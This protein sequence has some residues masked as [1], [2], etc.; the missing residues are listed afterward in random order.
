MTTELYQE[1]M[2]KYDEKQSKADRLADLRRNEIYEKL[3]EIQDI[4][5]KLLSFNLSLV[6][7]MADTDK[8]RKKTRTEDLKTEMS[9]LIERKAALLTSNGYPA[10][11]MENVYE[12]PLC[13]DTG[14]IENEQCSCFKQAVREGLFADSS[15]KSE[16]DGETFQDFSLDYYSDTFDPRLRTSIRLYMKGV[17]DICKRFSEKP[18]GN[19][20][21]TGHTGLG[22]SYLCHAI[23][24]GLLDKNTDVICDSSFMI[25]DKLLDIRFGRDKDSDYADSI[26]GC[27]VLIID[28]L[29]SE[30]INSAVNTELFNLLNYRLI[31][32]LPTVISTNLSINDIKNTYS[33]RI[34]SRLFGEYTII[35]FYGEDIRILKKRR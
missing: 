13:H 21:F 34:F 25:L 30:N 3:P 4:D 2:R 35:P 17:L 22:K 11:Y 28:D 5:N 23:A 33:E 29:G 8:D 15:M 7:I 32:K 9:S 10:D 6:S 18:K 20:L 12:C 14:F 26:F 31:N 1:I 16:N 24:K 19:L 27:S